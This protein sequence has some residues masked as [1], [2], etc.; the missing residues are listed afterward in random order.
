MPTPIFHCLK[1]LK[2]WTFSTM[3]YIQMEHTKDG[4]IG[5]ICSEQDLLEPLAPKRKIILSNTGH[6]I[7]WYS[8]KFNV[9]AGPYWPSP[10]SL[11][12]WE[13]L[14]PSKY[15]IDSFFLQT[16]CYFHFYHIHSSPLLYLIEFRSIWRAP[17]S[18]S[19]QA[20]GPTSR[21]SLSQPVPMLDT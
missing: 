6:Y 12:I 18:A 2:Q 17:A 13:C 1:I 14:L 7:L 19:H 9:S 10:I 5:G 3:T 11:T 4:T 8:R 16:Y 20:R 21:A 15:N